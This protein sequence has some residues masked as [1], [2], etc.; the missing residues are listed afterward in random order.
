MRKWIAAI[1]SF[2]LTLNLSGTSV[3]TAQDSIPDISD[4]VIGEDFDFDSLDDPAFLQ[5]LE[6]SVYAN[7]ESEF[8]ADEA[9]YQIDDVSVS[10]VSKEYL[11]ETAYN[12]KANIF[13]GYNIAQI[14]EVFQG[15]KYVFTLSDEGDTAVQEF[16][17]IPND[18]YDRVIKNVLIGSGVILICVTVTVLTAGAAAPAAA[19]GGTSV[20]SLAA[21][22]T[23]ATAAKVHMIFAASAHTAASFAAKGALFAGTTSF[24]TRGF[25]TGWDMDAM[26]ESALVNSSEG[27]MW[28]AIS[29][30]VI[31]GGSKAFQLHKVNRGAITPREAEQAAQA[32]YG[33]REQVTYLNGEEVPYGTLGGVRPDVVVGNE[34]IEVKCYDLRHAANLYELCRTLK[35][36][37]SQRVLNLPKHMTQRIVLNVE[38]RGLAKEYVQKVMMLIKRIIEPIYHDIP[39]DVMGA[40]I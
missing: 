29:G 30:A 5:Y 17:E 37:I 8:A 18:T 32:Y 3:A 25:E 1:V 26:A 16:L 19:A 2:I 27:F 24:V 20:A 9:V 10:F 35:T 33:G 21:T 31:G 23:I 34:A 7:L 14:N 11:E 6:D 38:G 28:G 12:S 22:G 15:K 39:I 13:F 40:M 4:I 36:E